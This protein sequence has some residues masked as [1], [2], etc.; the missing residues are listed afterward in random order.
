MK[1]P[2]RLQLSRERTCCTYNATIHRLVLSLASG[3]AWSQCW[4]PHS[5]EVTL[6]TGKKG[7]MGYAGR[8]CLHSG[9]T[10]ESRDL[11]ATRSFITYEEGL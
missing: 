2:A 10:E 3:N 6:Q 8:Y 4:S 7:C 1:I 9:V 5:S 11:G